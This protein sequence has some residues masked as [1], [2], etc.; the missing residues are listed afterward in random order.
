M[1]ASPLGMNGFFERV[2]CIARSGSLVPPSPACRAGF[3][4]ADRFVPPIVEAF[5]PS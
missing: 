4:L 2:R 3:F 5:K 1:F